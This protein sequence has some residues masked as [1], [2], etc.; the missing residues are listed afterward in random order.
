M[1]QNHILPIALCI[2]A[3]SAVSPVLAQSDNVKLEIN[4][5]GGHTSG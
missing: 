1:K 2:S 4:A 3:M 5:I